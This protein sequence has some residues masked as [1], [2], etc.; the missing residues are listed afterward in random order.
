[1]KREESSA[2]S[3]RFKKLQKVTKTAL[4]KDFKRVTI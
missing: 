4:T 2:D 3:E 1:M